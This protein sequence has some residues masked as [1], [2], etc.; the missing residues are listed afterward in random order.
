MNQAATQT[1]RYL[2]VVRGYAPEL[3]RG[4]AFRREK[5]FVTSEKKI[6]KCPY[7]TG[8]LKAVDIKIKVELYRYPQK[9]T[10]A[11]HSSIPCKVCHHKVGIIFSSA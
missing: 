8:T 1:E 5:H 3:M 6:L 2:Y 9:K 7:C 4:V 11:C 10:V